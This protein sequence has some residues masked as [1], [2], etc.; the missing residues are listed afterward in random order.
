VNGGLYFNILHA[1]SQWDV[2]NEGWILWQI[3]IHNSYVHK[4]GEFQI[5]NIITSVNEVEM[6]L[7]KHKFTMNHLTVIIFLV[8]KTQHWNIYCTPRWGRDSSIITQ[9]SHRVASPGN[10]PRWGT[11]F[12]APIQTGPGAHPASYTMGTGSFQR[13]KRPERGTDHPPPT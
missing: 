12:S 1:L 6:T 13:L 3:V 9:T 8:H 7:K 4:N 11:R 2:Q 5:S 10:E